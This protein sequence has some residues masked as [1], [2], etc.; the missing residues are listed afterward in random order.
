MLLGVV[1]MAFAEWVKWAEMPARPPAPTGIC[2][3]L[4]LRIMD[5]AGPVTPSMIAS[6]RTDFAKFIADAVDK[7]SKEKQR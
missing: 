4:V 3:E 7:C 6:M 1:P 2:A 5:N